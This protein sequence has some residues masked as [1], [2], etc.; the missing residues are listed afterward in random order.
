MDRHDSIGKG[1]LGMDFFRKI[2]QDSTLNDIPF[3]LE[4]PDETLWSQEISLLH[5]LENN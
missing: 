4:T 3:I 5:S 1:F 2:M